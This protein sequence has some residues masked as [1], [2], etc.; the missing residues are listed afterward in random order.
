MMVTVL[1]H[2]GAPSMVSTLHPAAAIEAYD[3]RFV[4]VKFSKH[5]LAVV[6]GL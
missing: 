5:A 3:A 2:N 4:V 6:L 1:F